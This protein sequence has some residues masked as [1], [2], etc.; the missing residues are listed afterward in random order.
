MEMI[1]IITVFIFLMAWSLI[2]TTLMAQSRNFYEWE[3]DEC[4]SGTVNVAP[5]NWGM[6]FIPDA[7]QTNLV[8]GLIVQRSVLNPARMAISGNESIT[9]LGVLAQDQYQYTNGAWDILTPLKV[10]TAGYVRVAV[11]EAINEDVPWTSDATGRAKLWT[12]LMAAQAA[13]GVTKSRATV[14]GEII[15]AQITNA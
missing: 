10:I 3:G 2:M 9:I 4:I 5:E 8:A 1:M 15:E 6:S 13:K 7:N 11:G 12:P 14:G